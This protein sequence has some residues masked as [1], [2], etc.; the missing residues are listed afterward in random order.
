MQTWAG[1][2]LDYRQS[3]KSVILSPS[4]IHN[5]ITSNDRGIVAFGHHQKVCFLN[6]KDGSSYEGPGGSTITGVRFVNT[7]KMWVLTVCSNNGTQVF[8]EDG[9]QMIFFI[10]LA[11]QVKEGRLPYH[12]G[13]AA[14]LSTAG[15]H[16]CV[17]TSEGDIN[18]VSADDAVG[19]LGLTKSPEGTSPVSDI[20][21]CN[22]TAQLVSVHDAGEVNFWGPQASGKYDLLAQTKVEGEVPTRCLAVVSS[23][24]VAFGSG[25]IRVWD[26]VARELRVEISAHARWINSMDCLP[27]RGIF[28]SVGEDTVMNV[29]LMDPDSRQISLIHSSVV[30]DK[31]LCGIAFTG[32]GAGERSPLAVTAYDADQ[33]YVYDP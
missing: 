8:S 14:S 12:K 31:L 15:S 13:V 16:I 25:V 1:M 20:C 22:T 4:L 18:V 6:T 5:N 33:V 17:G 32:V 3:P 21:F 11:A 19:P 27:D 24:L 10:P 29:W 28:A 23:L 9:S 26:I 7:G 2:A 30:A